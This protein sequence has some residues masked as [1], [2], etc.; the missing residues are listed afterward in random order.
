MR[1]LIAHVP[2]EYRGGEDVHVDVLFEVYKKL[3]YEVDFIP[4]KRVFHKKKLRESVRSLLALNSFSDFDHI[5]KTNRPDFIHMHNAFPLL[6]PRFFQW[7]LEKKIPLLMTIHNHRFYCTNGLAL[8]AGKICK[9]CLNAKTGWRPLLYNCNSDFVK[10]LYHAM[11]ITEMRAL[12]LYSKSVRKFIAT[13][14]YVQNELIRSGI[15]SKQ[16]VHILNPIQPN[17][18][19]TVIENGFD[20]FYA[21]RLSEEKGIIY[22]LKAAKFLPEL[23]IGIVGDGPLKQLVERSAETLKNIKYMGVVD[24]KTALKFMSSS[25]LGVL[26]SI[27]NEILPTS[28]MEAFYFGKPCVI[29]RQES[30]EWLGSPPFNGILVKSG[31]AEDL[32]Q[33]IRKGISKQVSKDSINT[34]REKLSIENFSNELSQVIKNI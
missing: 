11:A 19:E 30:T 26:P 17:I 15:P 33:G 32:A 3:G 27:C 5:L 20:V 2:Y 6:G 1:V 25:R 24:S 31:D 12:D 4:K 34:I 10:T 28:V 13:S 18:T 22:L 8:R 16:V 9:I 29:A 23:S 7:V 14:P 21:G